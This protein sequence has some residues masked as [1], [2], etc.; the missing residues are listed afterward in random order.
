MRKRER[1][2]CEAAPESF[3][4]LNRFGRRFGGLMPPNLDRRRDRARSAQATPTPTPTPTR[5]PQRPGGWSFWYPNRYPAFAYDSGF[6]SRNPDA[7]ELP[8]RIRRGLESGRGLAGMEQTSPSSGLTSWRVGI[9]MDWSEGPCAVLLLDVPKPPRS[10]RGSHPH[11]WW[12]NAGISVGLL[13]AVWMAISPTVGR[14]ERL[15]EDVRRSAD[16][17]Y[18]HP[19]KTPR[20]RLRLP[21]LYFDVVGA[22]CCGDGPR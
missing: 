11:V 18:E 10:S 21:L 14:I 12:W 8:E 19:I 1:A 6:R 3:S 4:E 22:S 7:P 13:L 16:A 15:T 5:G 20:R 17:R 9:K 2:R